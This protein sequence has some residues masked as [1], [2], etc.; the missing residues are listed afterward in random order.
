VKRKN[1]KT[2]IVKTT[3]ARIF[4][5][6]E[7]TIEMTRMY[8]SIGIRTSPMPLNFIKIIRPKRSHQYINISK[9]NRMHIYL[10]EEQFLKEFSVPLGTNISGEPSKFELRGD[11][12]L[13]NFPICVFDGKF[14]VRLTDRDL[15]N[16]I[17]KKD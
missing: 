17:L 6:L 15:N 7:F 2:N 5:K 9:Y 12:E 4:E 8:K 3:M 13:L 14:A 10:S 1:F 11:I 16:F